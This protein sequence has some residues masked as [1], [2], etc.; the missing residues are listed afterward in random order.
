MIKI[1]NLS[2]NFDEKIIFDNVEFDIPDKKLTF[3][4]GA[5]GMGKTTLFKIL[6][7]NI[8]VPRA[9]I[10]SSFKKIFFLPQKIKY[11]EKLTLYEYVTSLFFGNSF[12]WFLS[13]E[14]VNKTNNIL[15]LLELSDRKNIMI[16]QLSS[17]ELQKANIAMALLS[18]ADCLLLDEPT[19][20]MDLINQLKILDIIKKL[21]EKGITSVIIMHDINTAAQYGD[22]FFGINQKHKVIC[23][24]KNVF[25]T[26]DNLSDIFGINFI[27]NHCGND[28][29]IKMPKDM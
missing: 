12:K 26:A 27:V 7:N 22:Y 2:L 28:I 18:E 17:G 3:L 14:D 23:G 9:E 1:K 15:E 25:Y 8:S 16:E 24:Q 20:N 13:K 10:Y 6:A 4:I 5:N 21:N 29:N 11:P 19:S